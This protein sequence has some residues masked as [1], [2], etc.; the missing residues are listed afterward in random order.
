MSQIYSTI[1]AL[2]YSTLIRGVN[3]SVFNLDNI[4]FWSAGFAMLFVLALVFIPF[5]LVS[6]WLFK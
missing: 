4:A 1:Y 5:R 6:R 3:P 2:I